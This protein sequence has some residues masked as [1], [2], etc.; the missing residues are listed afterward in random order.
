[1]KALQFIVITTLIVSFAFATGASAAYYVVQDSM[2]TRA[3]TN[4]IPG[5]GWTVLFGPYASKDA[6]MRDS[7]IGTFSLPGDIAGAA[8]PSVTRA[9][10]GF[11]SIEVE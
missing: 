1:M 8:A 6:A 3:V 11:S 4:S 10:P 2:G 7:G 5:Y 9:A